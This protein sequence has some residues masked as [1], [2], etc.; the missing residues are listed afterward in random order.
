MIDKTTRSVVRVFVCLAILASVILLMLTAPALAQSSPCGTTV[1]GADWVNCYPL[2]IPPPM[3]DASPRIMVEYGSS[4]RQSILEGSTLIPDIPSRIVVEYGSS[5]RCN[6]LEGTTLIPNIPPRILVE[7]ASSIRSTTTEG[8]TAIPDTPPRVI[9]EYASSIR[10]SLLVPMIDNATGNATQEIG[11]TVQIIPSAPEGYYVNK[12]L[13]FEVAVTNPTDISGINV[14]AYNVQLA[15]VLPPEIEMTSANY[16]LGDLAPGEAKTHTF[17]ATAKAISDNVEVTVNASGWDSI[18]WKPIAGSAKC[19]VSIHDPSTPPPPNEWSFAVITDLHIGYGVEPRD[20]D[21]DDQ[22]VELDYGGDGYGDTQ[23]E[24]GGSGRAEKLASVI[25][26]I[27][28]ER[29]PRNIKF[30]VVLGDISDTAE[31]SEFLKAEE[32]L[33]RLNDPDG[34][35]NESDG[36][37]YIP[38]FGN[39]DTWPYTQD[40]GEHSLWLKPK[41]IIDKE[42]SFYGSI[43]PF[44]LGDRYFREV[45]WADPNKLNRK[46]IDKVF[47]DSWED[48]YDVTLKYTQTFGIP[49]LAYNF[50]PQDKDGNQYFDNWNKDC[51]IGEPSFHLQNYGFTYEGITFIALDQVPRN[52]NDPSPS[53]GNPLPGMVRGI[54]ATTHDLTKSFAREYFRD[55]HSETVVLFSHYPMGVEGV[56]DCIESKNVTRPTRV[57]AFGGH[58]HRNAKQD[59]LEDGIQIHRILTEDVGRVPLDFAGTGLKLEGWE[60]DDYDDYKEKVVRIVT[61]E[62]GG[63]DFKTVLEPR[64]KIDILYPSPFIDYTFASYPVPNNEIIFTAHFTTYHGF[65]YSFQ[66]DFGD[67]NSAS[68]SSVTHTYSQD[69]LYDVTLTVTI[70]N[71]IT[72]EET[73]ETVTEPVYVHSKYLIDSLPANLNAISLISEEDLTQV[74]KNTYEPALI[75]KSASAEIPV[76]GL[77]IHFEE[78]TADIDLSSLVAD[79]NLEEAKS[80]LYM[81]SWP[82]EIEQYKNLFIPSTGAGGVY[83]CS[84]ATSLDEV[85]LDNADLTINVGETKDGITVDTTIYNGREYYVVSGITGTGGGELAYTEFT[86]VTGITREVN[87]NTSAGVS[88]TLDDTGPVVSDQNG[89]FQIMATTTGNHTVVTHKD[90]FR[91]RTRTINIAGLGTGYAVTCNFQGQYGLIPNAPDIWYALDCV[92]LWLYPPD[93]DTGLDIWTALDVINAWLYPVQ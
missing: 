53:E 50:K 67:G 65:E 66:W 62:D 32:L 83:I 21:G 88:I 15:V 11:L 70:K 55:H 75:A 87:G 31:K 59:D 3:P 61:V 52:P 77:G 23:T 35:G 49:C 58:A 36:I 38:L 47:K 92:N 20:S 40:I 4:I 34:D 1:E 9:A 14:T 44:A 28:D 24:S 74:P 17:T 90:G 82:T 46:L 43:A 76:G 51:A 69:G 7:Y 85:T 84:N 2:E 72:G 89:Q 10:Q 19:Y 5:I 12:P 73:T 45:F 60:V 68:G 56:E 81:P 48:Q 91:D 39:H 93:P 57:Y 33:K 42:R 27:I 37:P 16:Y 30:V 25:Q 41:E 63:I 18:L 6:S 26:R 86:P 79:I 54:F 8:S 71:L 64:E 78:A 13:E 80:V 22:K 29:N